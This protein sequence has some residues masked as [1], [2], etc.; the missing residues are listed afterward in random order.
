MEQLEK[1]DWV[2]SRRHANH[3]RYQKLLGSQ[4]YVQ[5]WEDLEA[6]VSSISF[7]LLAQT[8]DERRAVI[9]NLAEYGIET[10]IFSAGNLGRHPFWTG[11]FGAT[12]FTFAD[13]LYQ[14]GF[15]LPNHP[16][17]EEDDIEFISRAACGQKS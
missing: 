9:M 7:C 4:F 2:A 1:L 17:L 14:T 13:R 5:R 15:F 11:R 3:L 6:T 8:A 16:Y 10:R 12:N